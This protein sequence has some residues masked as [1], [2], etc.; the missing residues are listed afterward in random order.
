MIWNKYWIWSVRNR[1]KYKKRSFFDKLDDI[2]HRIRWVLA[3]Y[4]YLWLI[5]ES[6]SHGVWFHRQNT[7]KILLDWIKLT[8][9][10]GFCEKKRCHTSDSGEFWTIFCR[11]HISFLF[12]FSSFNKIWIQS[13]NCSALRNTSS[14]A[15][16]IMAPFRKLWSANSLTGTTGN[17]FK[18]LFHS[19]FLNKKYFTYTFTTFATNMLNF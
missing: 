6:W 15:N 10:E 19:T 4:V 9:D 14:T 16:L 5:W 17:F 13:H 18:I 7:A 12:F 1:V 3:V 8:N 2:N 11:I